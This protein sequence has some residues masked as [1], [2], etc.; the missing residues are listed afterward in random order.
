MKKL[1]LFTIII[2]ITACCLTSNISGQSA[3]N[4]GENVLLQNFPNP[5]D[6][7]TTVKFTLKEDCYVKMFVSNGQTRNK[8]YLVD[9]EMSAG[10]HGIV[11][12]TNEIAMSNSDKNTGYIC[13]ME[14]YSLT[15][16]IQLYTS[17]INMIQ[18]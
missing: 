2:L 15:G 5:F 3:G 16:N 12:K 1:L 9:G 18:K 8:S 14:V 6:I 17:D 10:D 7:T 4:Y 11:F 13:T